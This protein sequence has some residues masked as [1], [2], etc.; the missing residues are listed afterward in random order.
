MRQLCPLR[1]ASHPARCQ[2]DGNGGVVPL[3]VACSAAPGREG[4]RPI[5][6]G[7]QVRQRLRSTHRR[8]CQPQHHGAAAGRREALQRGRECQIAANLE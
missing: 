7:R 8:T 6:P 1:C 5:V 2:L 3:V 4:Y